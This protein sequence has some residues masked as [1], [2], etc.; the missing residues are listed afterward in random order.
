MTEPVCSMPWLYLMLES[1]LSSDTCRKIPPSPT[2]L[3]DPGVC[4]DLQVIAMRWGL[5]G[6]I[7]TPLHR[8]SSHQSRGG[9]GNK[10]FPCREG[11]G[12]LCSVS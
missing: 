6:L 12:L 2:P 10:A 4:G 7:N 1:H 9:P 8:A 5:Q 11:Q 3:K